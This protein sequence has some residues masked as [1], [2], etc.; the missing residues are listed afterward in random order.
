MAALH[1]ASKVAS[2]WAHLR[3]GADWDLLPEDVL[4]GFPW[5]LAIA[6]GIGEPA[7]AYSLVFLTLA[8][9]GGGR[10]AA[11]AYLFRRRVHP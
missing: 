10:Y 6:G 8:I 5:P 9:T 2:A 11:D 7:A 1:G 4:L 3:H